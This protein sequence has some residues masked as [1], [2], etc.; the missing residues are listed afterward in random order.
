MVSWTFI[1]FAFLGQESVDAAHAA[2]CAQDQGK[3][4]EYHDRLFES[5]ANENSGSF[6]REGLN[7][8][9]QEVGL[10]AAEFGQCMDSRKYDNFIAAQRAEGQRIGISSTPTLIVNDQLLPGFI[11]FENAKTDNTIVV[12]PGATVE[13]QDKLKP[14]AKICLEGEV[15]N[16]RR[17][18]KGTVSDYADTDDKLC[19]LIKA[20]TPPSSDKAGEIGIET[21]VIG[22]KQIIEQELKAKK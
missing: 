8:L 20:Y 14:T 4:W 22:L 9:A 2:H 17:L 21:D 18:T 3:Y 13:G 5:R 11:P 15:D 7:K 16:Q 6:N 19:G 1:D 10:N 12:A